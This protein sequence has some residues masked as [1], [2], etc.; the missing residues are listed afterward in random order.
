MVSHLGAGG[1][2]VVHVQ[3]HP[4]VREVLGRAVVPRPGPRGADRS[5]PRRSRRRSPPLDELDEAAGASS[6]T[7]SIRASRC[8]KWCWMTPQVTPARRAIS[9]LLA[10]EA[11]SRMQATA[12]SMTA[13]GWP[14]RRRRPGLDRPRRPHVWWFGLLTRS[15]YDPSARPSISAA[16]I[17]A[18]DLAARRE[19]HRA[20]TTVDHVAALEAAEQPAGVRT[21][22]VCGHRRPRAVRT[23]PTPRLLAPLDGRGCR[24]RRPAH[25]GVAQQRSSISAGAMFSPPRIT[26]S[27][28]RPAMYRYPSSSTQPRSPGRQPAVGLRVAS[29]PEV[30]PLTWA[31][32]I[33]TRPCSPAGTALPSSSTMLDLDAGHRPADRGERPADHGVAGAAV[34]CSSGPRRAIVELVSVRP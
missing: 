3:Q 20:A 28:A 10:V 6:S 32:R 14:A 21:E 11:A 13:G 25:G 24:R 1:R 19:R 26:T 2:V 17:S 34:R 12:A 8:P 9:L 30:A 33:R 29:A 16:H 15:P 4:H 5:A 27:S 31:P 22:V 18:N 23:R 7:A